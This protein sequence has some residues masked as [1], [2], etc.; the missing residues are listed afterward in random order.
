M[1]KKSLK[2]II[3][4]F[5]IILLISPAYVHATTP[6][7]MI[8]PIN[9]GQSEI[10]MANI[11]RSR[12]L[13]VVQIVGAA[14]AVVMLMVLGIKYMIAA[15]DGKAQIKNQIIIYVVG[16]VLLFG[17]SGIAGIIRTFGTSL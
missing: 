12:I 15:P 7:D 11:W 1:V 2:I 13:L 4:I 10:N 3:I 8:K 16:A 14:I 5:T 6:I 9:P 17:A